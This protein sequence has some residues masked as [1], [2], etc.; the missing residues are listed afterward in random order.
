MPEDVP[1]LMP[2]GVEPEAAWT[3]AM[4]LPLE[5]LLLLLPPLEPL[6]PP[7]LELPPLEP[8]LEPPLLPEL[9]LGVLVD[10]LDVV[11]GVVWW[12]EDDEGNTCVVLDADAER[13]EVGALQEALRLRRFSGLWR[14]RILR[15]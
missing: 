8:P 7:P 12:V 2:L 4:E 14:L 5:L 10:S 11:V 1:A 3:L 9:L 13:D 6:E 15:G